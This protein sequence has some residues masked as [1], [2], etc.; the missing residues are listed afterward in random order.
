MRIS[1]KPQPSDY[2]WPK[3]PREL[4]EQLAWASVVYWRTPGPGPK[5]LPTELCEALDQLCEAARRVRTR[6]EVDAELGNLC[7]DLEAMPRPFDLDEVTRIRKRIGE[8]VREVT[9]DAPSPVSPAE[10][11]LRDQLEELRGRLVRIYHLTLTG[12][13]APATL[14]A[15]RAAS[16]PGAPPAEGSNE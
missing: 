2:D 1:R 12:Q 9:E 16:A 15:V 13:D 14:R 7:R 3:A 10:L 6:A 4:L 8:V 5:P 11:R